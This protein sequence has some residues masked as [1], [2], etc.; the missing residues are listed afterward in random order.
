[1][2]NIRKVLIF[3]SFC[4]FGC[5]YSVASDVGV[6]VSGRNN[7]LVSVKNNKKY[8]LLPIDEG[9]PKSEISLLA[10]GKCVD[11]FTARLSNIRIDYYTPVDVSAYKDASILLNIVNPENVNF[12]DYICWGKIKVSDTFDSS[13]KEAFRPAY[14]HTPAYG[15][16]NDPNGMFYDAKKGLWHLYYQY[17][18]YDSK[19][20]NMTWGHSVSKD[21]VKWEA[22]PAAIKPDAL[23][24]IFS[25]SCVLDTMNTAGYGKDAVIAFYTSAA[26]SQMQ[27]MAYSTDG[28]ETFT[29]YEGNPVITDP[30]ADFRDPKVFYNSAR[31][32][33]TMVLACGQEIKFYSSANLKDWS[34]DSSFGTGVGCHNGVW[35]CPDLF[36]LPVKG[37]KQYKW[38]LVV[39]INPGGPFGGSATQYFIGDYDGVKFT[40]DQKEAKWMDYGK[41]HY[42]TV[43]FYNAPEKRCVVMAWMSNWQYAE[44]L[45]TKQFRSQNSVARDLGLF[46]DANGE[47]WLSVLP[48]KENN[49]LYGAQ[50]LNTVLSSA[51]GGSETA[52]T[53]GPSVFNISLDMKKGSDVS[54]TFAN[55]DG[56][57]A[58]IKYNSATSEVS[59]ARE[60]YKA[61][62]SNEFPAETK[63]VLVKTKGS[64][65][66]KLNLT[67]FVDNCSMELFDSEGRM[68]MTNLVFPKGGFSSVKV[69]SEKG[70]AKVAIKQNQINQ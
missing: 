54:L 5:C 40:S 21:L 46:K 38:V 2:E 25:G 9:A 13:N 16:M 39:N 19:W 33:W 59:F 45:P 50:V 53:A 26:A 66:N 1:M 44:I 64:N 11:K 60:Q 63:A 7:V 69:A 61:K 62:V 17:N 55:A 68:A 47:I 41:D 18:P 67:L 52:I 14:H 12:A 65:P 43:S 42:A 27:S 49:A 58:V 29:P 23:G 6:L 48:S 4:F 36:L 57:T 22:R 10:D 34:F 35:E 3:L 30:A 20:G 8:I 24:M 56:E 31:G 70:S 32:V 28:G 15:W 51:K 37:T